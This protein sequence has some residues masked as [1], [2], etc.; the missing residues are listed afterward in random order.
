MH[1]KF[2]KENAPAIYKIATKKGIDERRLRYLS[3]AKRVVF[4]HFESK[5]SKNDYQDLFLC[6]EELL[7]MRNLE[8][9][10][11]LDRNIES[12]KNQISKL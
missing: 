12:F 4:D 11:R 3:H 9:I 6:V 10:D 7:F 8:L 1:N 2:T 5:L